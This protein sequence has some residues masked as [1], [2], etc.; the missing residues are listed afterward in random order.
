MGFSFLKEF[1]S[2][3]EQRG[4]VNM[5]VRN[6]VSVFA[7]LCVCIVRLFLNI[8]RGTLNKLQFFSVMNG[9]SFRRMLMFG[10][11]EIFHVLFYHLLGCFY[12]F[13]K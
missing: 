7:C 4:C 6:V 12:Q 11:C 2:N 9:R 8:E 3:L 10:T 13:E 5:C 1:T